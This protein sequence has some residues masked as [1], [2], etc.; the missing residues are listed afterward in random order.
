MKEWTG[1]I[2]VCND[3]VAQLLYVI[4]VPCQLAAIRKIAEIRFSLFFA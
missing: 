3:I 1:N 2:S 4:I